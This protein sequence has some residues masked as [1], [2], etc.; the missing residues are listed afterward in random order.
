MK[1]RNINENAKPEPTKNP[2]EEIKHK[3]RTEK[4]S[5]MELLQIACILGA[6]YGYKSCEK[7]NNIQKML[8]DL[9]ETMKE[10]F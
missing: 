9:Q 5:H 4:I 10:A 8:F 2:L 3:L 1:I 7:G 6:E